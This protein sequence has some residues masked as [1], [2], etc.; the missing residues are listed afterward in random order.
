MPQAAVILAHAKWF[1]DWSLPFPT[2][3]RFMLDPASIAMIVA[4]IALTGAWM[5]AD[6]RVGVPDLPSH[7]WLARLQ[8]ALPRLAAA[9]LGL[10]LVALT[11]TGSFLAPHLSAHGAGWG[12]VLL[13][14]LI[15]VWL[16][17]GIQLRQAAAALGMLAA[18][19]LVLLGPVAVL[20]AAHMWGIAWFLG[21]TWA[22][23]G[24][25]AR[26]LADGR[27][28]TGLLGLRLGVGGALAAGAMSE[29]LMDP[30]FFT[31]I[32]E[33]HPVMNLPRMVG[34]SLDT[35]TVTRLAGSVELLFALLI[36]AGVTPRRWP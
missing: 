29:K 30:A 19:G 8:P 23:D 9:S 35:A 7:R 17:A 4:V 32:L 33:A 21:M 2:N 10:S 24:H 31:A 1:V 12:I 36:I 26:P 28:Q 27:W 34:L 20:E 18:A 25:P 15:G 3:W 13:Q 11:V 6:R 5:V 22:L 14:G 16:I